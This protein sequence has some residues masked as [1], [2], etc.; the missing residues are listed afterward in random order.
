[1]TSSCQS[2]E[3][4]IVEPALQWAEAHPSYFFA[5]GVVS[6]DFMVE[7]LVVGAQVLGATRVELRRFR[8]WHVV[9]AS[10]DWFVSARFPVPEDFN[11]VA[12]TP[13]PELGPNC[14]RPECVV[15]AFAEA[16]IVRGPSAIRV[17]KGEVGENDPVL[18]EIASPGWQR[19]VAFRLPGA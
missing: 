5:S 13:F 2:P 14:V 16:V 12:L 10:R 8:S 17:V 18:G 15:A 6:A 7:Q 9:A 11:F 19:A 1:M 3:I 4:Q